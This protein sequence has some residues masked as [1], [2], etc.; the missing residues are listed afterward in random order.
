MEKPK[1]QTIKDIAFEN[2]RNANTEE[3]REEAIKQ[4]DKIISQEVDNTD[5]PE[6]L[7]SLYYEALVH[8][9]ARAKALEKLAEVKGW[10]INS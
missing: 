2:F 7:S 8:S 6:E 1:E 3:E 10:K 5:L 9:P 4:I